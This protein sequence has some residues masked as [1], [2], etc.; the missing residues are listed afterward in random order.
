MKDVNDAY[1]QVINVK[2]KEYYLCFIDEK[3]SYLKQLYNYR[4]Q[5]MIEEKE[6]VQTFFQSCQHEIG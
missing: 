1:D 5:Q 3:E 4:L 6:V 2:T